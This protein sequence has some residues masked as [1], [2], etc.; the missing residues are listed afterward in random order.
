MN[1]YA[2]L[3]RFVGK[4]RTSRYLSDNL[5]LNT[6]VILAD[7]HPLYRQGIAALLENQSDYRIVAEVESAA[8]LMAAVAQA[9]PDLVI[10]DYRMPG[11]GALAAVDYLK[12]RHAD[13]KILM[14]TGIQS[15]TVLQQLADSRVDGVVLKDASGDELLR[16]VRAVLRGE[17]VLSPS[18]EPYLSGPHQGLSQREFQVLELICA[19]HSNQEIAERL[20]L[21]AKTVENHRYKAMQKLDVKNTAGLIKYARKNGLFES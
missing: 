6:H 5:A 4:L 7:D 12:R 14:L 15:S 17:R 2:L 3:V 8:A 20:A 18:L 11:M 9:L 16:S 19:G 21:S 1:G 13:L 10:L